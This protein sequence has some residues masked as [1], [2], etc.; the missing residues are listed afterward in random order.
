[1]TA[2]AYPDTVTGLCWYCIS[3]S[4]RSVREWYVYVTLLL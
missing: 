4:F 1:L 3:I 2:R